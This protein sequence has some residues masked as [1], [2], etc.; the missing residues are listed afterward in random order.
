MSDF[1]DEAMAVIEEFMTMR[2]EK[3]PDYNTEGIT[4]EQIGWAIAFRATCLLND[5]YG[6][7]DYTVH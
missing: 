4:Q 3:I 7:S 1:N 2:P 5:L 6:P